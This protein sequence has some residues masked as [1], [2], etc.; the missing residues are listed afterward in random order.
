[1]NSDDT[2]IHRGDKES[3]CLIIRHGVSFA[4]ESPFVGLSRLTQSIKDKWLI[5]WLKDDGKDIVNAIY[6]CY[7]KREGKMELDMMTRAIAPDFD[8]EE[9]MDV[10]VET[11]RDTDFYE[12]VVTTWLGVCYRSMG[13]DG[14]SFAGSIIEKVEAKS[15]YLEK[16]EWKFLKCIEAVANET[17]RVP[18][19]KEVRAL[20]ERLNEKA[21][22]NTFNGIK[23]RLGFS[24]LP[25]GTRGKRTKGRGFTSGI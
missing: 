9:S 20:W 7:L 18:L 10:W 17:N 19:Q 25:A 16:D 13:A 1:M 21:N 12:N 14:V 15:R 22:K 24:W 5:D 4:F 3:G 11:V 2:Q 8:S 23:K 6:L